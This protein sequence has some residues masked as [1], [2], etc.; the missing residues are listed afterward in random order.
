M[1]MKHL[2]QTSE[3]CTGV[4][5]SII[6]MNKTSSYYNFNDDMF[7]GYCLLNMRRVK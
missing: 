2:L 1:I 7:R 4:R 5:L 6:R 3:R